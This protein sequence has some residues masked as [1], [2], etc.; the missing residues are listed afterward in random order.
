MAHSAPATPR[1]AAGPARIRVSI[2]GYQEGSPITPP[3]SGKQ[4]PAR[5]PELNLQAKASPPKAYKSRA[6]G[7][8]FRSSNAPHVFKSEGEALDFIRR[9]DRLWHG[10]SCQRIGRIENSTTTEVANPPE[11]PSGRYAKS[12]DFAPR[13]A[14]T[15]IATRP[16]D[17]GFADSSLGGRR[18]RSLGPP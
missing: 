2:A 9:K 6:S 8:A 5:Y 14:S 12:R 15:K 10:G 16:G 7:P 3:V 4:Q 17:Q 1:S 13:A 11:W 18:I